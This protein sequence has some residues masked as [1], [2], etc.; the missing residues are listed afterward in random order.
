MLYSSPCDIQRPE[1]G[2]EK[3]RNSLLLIAAWPLFFVQ[4][5]SAQPRAQNAEEIADICVGGGP[6]WRP[7]LEDSR[8]I[9]QSPVPQS[10]R[11]MFESTEPCVR[12]RM[13][14]RWLIDWHLNFGSVR[15]TESALAYL[16]ADYIKRLPTTALYLSKVR[17]AHRSAIRDIEQAAKMGQPAG[18][19][20]SAR[21]RYLNNS[22]TVQALKQLADGNKKFVELAELN[23]RTAEEF[24]S[25]TLLSKAQT[26]LASALETA[27]YLD[28]VEDVSPVRNMLHFNANVFKLEGLQDR[29]NVQRAQMT[30]THQDFASADATLDLRETPEYRNAAKGAYSGG[31]DF[32]E[33]SDGWDFKQAIEKACKADRDFPVKVINYWISRASLDLADKDMKRPAGDVDSFKWATRLLNLEQAPDHSRRWGSASASED[34][35]RLHLRAA[36]RDGARA[37]PGKRDEFWWSALHHLQRAEALAKAHQ[38]PGR[39]KRIANRWLDLWGR[40]KASLTVNQGSQGSADHQRYAAYLKTNLEGLNAVG[41]STQP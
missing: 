10:Y 35:L 37:V 38:S 41:A 9:E 29:I 18:V 22:R 2:R 5:L 20:Y 14:E 17:K 27:K 8:Q 33:I 7:S 19:S 24:N 23:L 36:E 39:F 30:M 15:S 16:E 11:S 1:K 32:C 40:R 25:P 28:L 6:G 12:W 4:P 31:D 34:L 21:A 3:L 26:Y 13:G